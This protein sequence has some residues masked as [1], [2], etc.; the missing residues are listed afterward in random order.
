MSTLFWTCFV[1]VSLVV[2]LFSHISTLG[3]FLQAPGSTLHRGRWTVVKGLLKPGGRRGWNVHLQCLN[4]N[5]LLK[6]SIGK[7]PSNFCYPR[8]ANWK[9]TAVGV[10]GM[11]ELENCILHILHYIVLHCL[12]I[13]VVSNSKILSKDLWRNYA[14]MFKDYLPY[15][16]INI[17]LSFPKMKMW[18]RPP[19]TIERRLHLSCRELWLS[20][21][22]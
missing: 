9:M 7:H 6:L 4:K 22:H 2:L 21:D 12:Y 1:S 13:S 19:G 18:C 5:L 11:S 15:I 10:S 16:S 20:S 14:T 3:G 17:C 8:T